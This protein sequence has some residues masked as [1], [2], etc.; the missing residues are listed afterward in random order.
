MKRYKV[1]DETGIQTGTAE[2]ILKHVTLKDDRGIASEISDMSVEQY[3]DALIKN[4]SYFLPDN[5][6]QELLQ[7]FPSSKYDLALNLLS[8]MPASNTRILP[9]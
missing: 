7:A 6:I 1:W 3:T 5:V 8:S 4:A 9:V 2:E